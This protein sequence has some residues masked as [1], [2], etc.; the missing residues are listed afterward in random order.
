VGHTFAEEIVT[1]EDLLLGHL[2][3]PGEGF[4][5]RAVA[6]DLDAVLVARVADQLTEQEAHAANIDAMWR[7]ANGEEQDAA[8]WA[9]VLR[10]YQGGVAQ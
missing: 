10:A 7:L 6:D 4:K 9:A 1:T 5:V 3:T 2:H 8:Y